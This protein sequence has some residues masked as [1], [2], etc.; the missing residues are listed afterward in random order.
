MT[1]EPYK[2]Q[3]EAMQQR[4]CCWLCSEEQCVLAAPFIV[5]VVVILLQIV[6]FVL[7]LMPSRWWDES[8][9][10]TYGEGIED[11]DVGGYQD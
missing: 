1:Q 7:Y 9:M 2:S 6:P 5:L 11:R 4:R 10:D 8:A 3:I